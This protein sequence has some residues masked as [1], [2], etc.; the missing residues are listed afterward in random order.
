MEKVFAGKTVIV[1]GASFGIG[2]ATALAFAQRGAKVAVV[3]YVDG[4]ETVAAIKA[5][6]G[7]ASFIKCDVSKD[8]EVK[9]MVE[10]TVKTFGGLDYAVNNAGT[11]GKQ[12]PMQDLSEADWDKTIDVNLKGVWLCMK[13]QIP[14]M[15]KKGKGAIVNMA[16]IAGVI[17][18]PTSGAYCA[19][20]HGVIGL[21]KVAALENATTG[22]RV[23]AI[24]PGLI[25][26]PM[27]ERAFEGSVEKE[28][29]YVMGVP[30]KRLGT[31][32]EISESVVH[33]CSDAS[34][35]TTGQALIIDGGW[36]A[37]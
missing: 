27:L 22:I 12:S 34:S 16:S 9:A 29:M 28:Q 33:L 2:R 11:E 13:Y 14:Q 3:D 20:K 37:Q 17:G 26:T 18:F 15:L 8:A 21:T 35:L 1:T 7:E 25:K 6:G 24:C 10:Q 31:P 36:V 4:S 32:E 30:M 23:N 5:L 19:S